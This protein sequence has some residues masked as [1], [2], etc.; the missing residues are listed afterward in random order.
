MP[1]KSH[2]TNARPSKRAARKTEPAEPSKPW[3]TKTSELPRYVMDDLYRLYHSLDKQARKRL[4]LAMEIPVFIQDPQVALQNPSLCIQKID[5]RLEADMS[6]GPTSSRITVVDFNADTQKLIEPVIWDKAVG[7]FRIPGTNGEWLPDPQKGAKSEEAHQAFIDAAVKNPY[8]HQ[9]NV[10]AVVQRVLEFYEEPQ[11]LGRP[12]PWGFDGN[13]L[14]VVPHAGYGE[15]AFYDQNSKSLQFYY[16]GDKEEPGYTCLSH[17]IIAHETGHAILDGIRPLYNQSSSVQTG[18][19]HEFIGDMTAILLSLS[20]NDIRRYLAKTTQGNLESADVLANI[21]EQFGEVVEEREYLRSA[22]NE[23]TMHHVQDSL[24]PHYVSEVLTGAMFEIL[25]KITRKRMQV[26]APEEPEEADLGEMPVSQ[27]QPKLSMSPAQALSR[28]AER[29]RR[30]VLQPL[31]LCP[32]CDIQFLDYASAVLRNDLLT[33]PVDRHGYR[34]IML[35]VFHHRGLCPCTYQTGLTMPDDC[36]FQP[37]YNLSELGFIQSDIGRV[38]RSRTAA[39]YF[40]SDNRKVLRIPSHQDVEVVDLYDN[41]KL[42]VAAER[43]PREMVLEYLW[44]EEVEL[45]GAEFGR[46]NGKKININCGGTLVFDERGNLLS[47]FRKPGTEHI[48]PAEVEDV[49]QRWQ[50]W[51]TNPGEAAT[52]KIKKVT[53]QELGELEDHAMGTQRKTALRKYIASLAKRNLVGEAQPFNPFMEGLKP[54]VAIE[55]NGALRFEM[56]PHLRTSDFD[57]EVEGWTINY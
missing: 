56:M 24:S 18:A 34:D 46:W 9:V 21:A 54:I 26:Q 3:G 45:G 30:I 32:P 38:S 52:K 20:N 57:T 12:I 14:L 2:K 11:A 10:W 16:F 49:Q 4:G 37:A 5:V 25:I 39:Y 40:L 43:L 23:L 19:F 29:F 31:D 55:E 35:E 50:E 8:F 7:W 6:D 28:T 47:W 48:S 17:D 51:K 13:R 15:N 27:G 44:R 33:N 22:T 36:L 41:S 1:R 53:R 42:G